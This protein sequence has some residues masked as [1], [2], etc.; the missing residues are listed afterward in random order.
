MIV[1]VVSQFCNRDGVG[2]GPTPDDRGRHF[3]KVRRTE[4]Q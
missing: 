4:P 1:L 3:F 2:R